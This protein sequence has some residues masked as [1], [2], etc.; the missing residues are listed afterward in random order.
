[1][2]Y[3]VLDI[4][5]IKVEADVNIFVVQRKKEK[6]GKSKYI[7]TVFKVDPHCLISDKDS[8]Y[9]KL[10][11]IKVGDRVNVD[12]IRTKDGELLAKGISVLN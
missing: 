3:R 5:V 4:K 9:L 8:F 12:F 7:K 11:D 2:A 1:M 10:S 6:M